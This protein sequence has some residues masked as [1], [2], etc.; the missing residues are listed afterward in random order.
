MLNLI[1]RM[2]EKCMVY[3]KWLLQ[4]FRLKLKCSSN[5]PPPARE[6]K[7]NS[8]LLYTIHFSLIRVIKFNI[9]K[10]VLKLTCLLV[11]LY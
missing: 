5:P 7:C 9:V 2:S 4:T 8:H 3:N 6:V 1:T 11:I 10:I